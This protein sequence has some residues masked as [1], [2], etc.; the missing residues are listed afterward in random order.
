MA[1]TGI[2]I[3]LVEDDA[4]HAEIVER[5]L[6]GLKRL[7]ALVRVHDGQEALDYLIPAAGADNPRPHLVLLDLRLPKVDGLEV[8]TR[9][10]ARADLRKIPVVVLTTSS[11]PQD[12][13]LA[14]ANGANSYLVKPSEFD[15]LTALMGSIETYW[16]GWNRFADA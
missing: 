16:A 15:E 7:R 6:R 2:V 8:L 3:L 13:S 9:I 10:K 4:A 11:A 1:Q 12:I 14:Y 5:H